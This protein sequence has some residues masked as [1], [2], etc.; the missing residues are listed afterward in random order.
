MA[1]MSRHLAGHGTGRTTGRKAYHDS[2]HRGRYSHGGDFE[3]NMQQR[4]YD[5]TTPAEMVPSP[6]AIAATDRS[7]RASDPDW[8]RAE[9]DDRSIAAV[10]RRTWSERR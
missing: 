9:A 7:V 10:H 2:T 1:A 3:I 5:G 8:K 6:V 4:R